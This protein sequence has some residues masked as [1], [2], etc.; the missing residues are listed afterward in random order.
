MYI[1]CDRKHV[2]FR[3]VVKGLDIL[4]KIEQVGTADGKPAQLVKIIDSGESFES[5][6]QDGKEKGNSTW[7]VGS[8]YI[9]SSFCIL[10]SQYGFSFR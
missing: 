10:I 2:V 3:K 5:E 7:I 4:K 6:I 1:S 9:I 8:N